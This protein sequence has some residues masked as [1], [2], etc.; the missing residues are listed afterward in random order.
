MVDYIMKMLSMDTCM[1]Q[2]QRREM[3]DK[4]AVKLT[5]MLPARTLRE[6]AHVLATRVL[7]EM[8]KHAVILM[9]AQKKMTV[10]QMLPA[11]T[12]RE[13]T[14]V[15]A[16]RVSREMEKR[17]VILMSAQ[18][19]MTVLQMLLARTPRGR[20]PVP[21]TR[22]SREMEKHA[23]LK[24]IIV[25]HMLP[26]KRKKHTSVTTAGVVMGRENTVGIF[27]SVLTSYL[28]ARRNH[29]S[30]PARRDMREMDEYAIKCANKVSE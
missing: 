4:N 5:R 21:A 20:T 25:L 3:V 6:Y 28:P 10:L 7:R 29:T 15:P 9:S 12:P 18:K 30:V 2:V 19:K 17:A 13:H 16:T 11:R 24:E 14:P 22:V 1:L 8:L 26:A 23:A 27:L